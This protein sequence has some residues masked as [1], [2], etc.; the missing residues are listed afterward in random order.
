[1]KRERRSWLIKYARCFA[2]ELLIN[3]AACYA[4]EEEAVSGLTEEECDFIREWIRNYGRKLAE[5]STEGG[6]DG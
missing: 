1:M 4:D 5:R 3:D 6:D 2:G